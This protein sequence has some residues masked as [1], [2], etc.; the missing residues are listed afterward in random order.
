[1][2]KDARTKNIRK[3]LSE[4]YPETQRIIIPVYFTDEFD[5]NKEWDCTR[6]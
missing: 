1:M 5:L 3:T 2:G 4:K 6:Q